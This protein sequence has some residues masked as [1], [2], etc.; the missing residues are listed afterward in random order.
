M[1]EDYHIEILDFGKNV[2]ASEAVTLNED[3]SYTIFLNSRNSHAQ[4]MESYKHAM[5][6]I[7]RGD[8]YSDKTA[9]QIE[10]EAHAM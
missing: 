6:H 9:D 2:T 7:L 10:A 3:G 4:N 8:F 5:L 1:M